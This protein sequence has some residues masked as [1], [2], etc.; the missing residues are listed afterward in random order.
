MYRHFSIIF[1][2]CCLRK[3]ELIL[4]KQF[5][6]FH[7]TKFTNNNSSQY[8]FSR[9]DGNWFKVDGYEWKKRREG[10]LIRED[11]MKLKR[12]SHYSICVY[13]YTCLN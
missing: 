13:R 8:I 4:F 1:E 7:F 9:F 12:L 5:A 6:Y 11:H 2:R 3:R 10:K